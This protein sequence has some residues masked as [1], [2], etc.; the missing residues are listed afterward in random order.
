MNNQKKRRDPGA[1]LFTAGVATV[2]AMVAPALLWVGCGGGT[3][4]VSGSDG[5]TN[6]GSSS[7]LC[8]TSCVD[9]QTDNANC[10]KCGAAC[11]A[12]EVCSS[13]ACSATCGTGLTV[14]SGTCVNEK[15]DNANCGACGTVCPAG[16]IGRASWRERV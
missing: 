6:C 16:Q 7:T 9:T 15:T 11:A 3:T 10:G 1:R 5:G 8:G 2:I 13:G 12:G 14:C 4:V